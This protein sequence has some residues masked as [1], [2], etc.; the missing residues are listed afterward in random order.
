M[1]VPRR[2]I[3]FRRP[4]AACT[5]RSGEVVAA[6]TPSPFF[7]KQHGGGVKGG[8]STDKYRGLP[9]APSF[10]FLFARK[11]KRQTRARVLLWEIELSPLLLVR[12]LLVHPLSVSDLLG[13]PFVKFGSELLPSAS[14]L[15]LQGGPRKCPRIVGVR[16]DCVRVREVQ[17]YF[18]TSD[19][20]TF[21]FLLTK[22]SLCR[23]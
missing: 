18:T 3:V 8:G 12:S 23:P 10:H 9:L 7:L 16:G 5:C 1:C 15:L 20:Q 4:P 2:V 21:I 11:T 14:Q 6:T 19:G 17:L 13:P 22:S